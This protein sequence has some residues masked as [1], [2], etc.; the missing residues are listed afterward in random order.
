MT[1]STVFLD[2]V[3]RLIFSI[4]LAKDNSS[5]N[6]KTLHFYVYIY[7]FYF[8]FCRLILN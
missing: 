5:S 6:V 7:S 2:A 4:M 3:D 8:L 1:E